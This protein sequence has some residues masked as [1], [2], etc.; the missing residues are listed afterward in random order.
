MLAPPLPP[1]EVDRQ[2]SPCVDLCRRIV[3]RGRGANRVGVDF[4]DSTVFVAV[5]P[6]FM[7]KWVDFGALCFA[8]GTV[9]AHRTVLLELAT[10]LFSPLVGAIEKS[11]NLCGLV[12]RIIDIA[13]AEDYVDRLVCNMCNVAVRGTAIVG[14]WTF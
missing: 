9:L 1:A 8:T 13:Y 2:W 3:R 12:G 5:T 10:C 14:S 6:D 11:G 7:F 4:A